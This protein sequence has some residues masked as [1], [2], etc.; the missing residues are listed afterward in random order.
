MVL[1]CLVLQYRMAL[2]MPVNRI[3]HWDFLSDLLHK[4]QEE[5]CDPLKGFFLSS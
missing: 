2:Q 3:Y 1:S 4:K 5:S